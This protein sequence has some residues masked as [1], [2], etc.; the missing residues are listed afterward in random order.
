MVFIRSLIS[1]LFVFLVLDAFNLDVK[2]P[3]YKHAG[4]RNVKNNLDEEEERHVHFGFS[5]AQ[6]VVKSTR[7]PYILVGAP[8]DT[9]MRNGVQFNMSGAI[10][11]C[12]IN[13]DRADDCEQ[14]SV[15]FESRKSDEGTLMH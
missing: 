1:L 2:S 11:K 9:F 15:D 8:Q 3:V 14:I 12:P 7:T 5:V 6:H 4:R 10:D 13:L